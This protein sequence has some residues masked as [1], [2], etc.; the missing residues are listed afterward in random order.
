MDYTTIHR[1]FIYKDRSSLKEFGIYD[2]HIINKKIAN[3]LRTQDF[4]Q[5]LNPEE[6]VV[7]CMNQAYYYCTMALLEDD[8]CWRIKQY[9][10]NAVNFTT[11]FTKE[12]TDTILS[13]MTIYLCMLPKERAQKVVDF[14][15]EMHKK[16]NGSDI[17]SALGKCVTGL[18]DLPADEFAPRQITNK[19]INEAFSNSNYYHNCWRSITNDYDIEKIAVL[20]SILGRTVEEKETMRASLR[21]DVDCFCDNERKPRILAQIDGMDF[22]SAE[23][24]VELGMEARY[25]RV[26]LENVVL[27]KQLMDV[28]KQLKQQLAEAESVKKPD[29]SSK[30]E[31]AENVSIDYKT[32]Y[33]KLQ[34]D[35]EKLKQAFEL[36]EKEWNDINSWAD[37]NIDY[38]E[39]WENNKTTN[40]QRIV[41]FTTIFSIALDKDTKKFYDLR[42]LAF[43]I[44]CLCN[45]KPSTIGPMLSRIISA[46]KRI[47]AKAADDKDYKTT[48]VLA[49]AA[50]SM[51]DHLELILRDTTKNDKHQT[52]NWIRDNLV[53]NYPMSENDFNE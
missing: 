4:I 7:R 15:Q 24:A 49:L 12:Y 16:L 46:N 35:Y 33:E 42:Q 27:E 1:E 22:S 26:L 30:T 34:E 29:C 10:Q 2:N 8:P 37:E 47:D 14:I 19:A 52:I 39:L 21:Y 41:F 44:S 5:W 32:N 40:H 31:N 50:Q 20:F 38:D 45:E 43:V 53:K 28:R 3:Y 36:M 13:M 51:R 6:N 11:S 25:G 17:Y 18:S 48:Q 9:E 23:H